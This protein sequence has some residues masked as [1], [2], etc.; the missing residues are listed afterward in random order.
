MFGMCNSES[1]GVGYGPM[2]Q[3]QAAFVSQQTATYCGGG[4]GGGGGGGDGS[5]AGGNGVENHHAAS[6]S[7]NSESAFPLNEQIRSNDHHTHTTKFEPGSH[8]PGGGG[9]GA[10]ANAV[11]AGG[12]GIVSDNGLQYANL[13]GSTMGYGPHP[14]YHHPHHHPHHGLP[15]SAHHAV[16]AAAA[17]GQYNEAAAVAAASHVGSGGNGGGG[18]GGATATTES[19]GLT[20][21]FSA[22]LENT[23]VAQYA[24]A[25]AAHPYSSLYHQP[26]LRS[27][28][29]YSPYSHV[30]KPA[31]NVPTYK[32]MQVKRNVPKPGR[33]TL[34]FSCR[35]LH[36]R[37][38]NHG[39]PFLNIFLNYL[40]G[41]RRRERQQCGKKI[42][43]NIF[44]DC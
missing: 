44:K 4:E 28:H 9:S 22:Y 33:H 40:K 24:S 17:Y 32:W 39:L 6:N 21:P 31:S 5:G 2:H 1:A 43:F 25:A 30:P 12:A 7:S 42:K 38:S 3:P 41:E 23:N 37:S 18:G 13:D 11:T 14:A 19:A 26:K 10:G 35:K 36:A 20:S 29:D 16:A 15:H 8:S 34:S 27:S